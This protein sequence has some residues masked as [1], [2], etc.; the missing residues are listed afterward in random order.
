MTKFPVSGHHF[1]VLEH[2]FP[3]LE[4]PF[5]FQIIFFLFRTS[6][7]AVS[8]F[9][10]RPVPDFGCPGPSRPGFYLSRCPEKLHRPVPLETLDET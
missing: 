5:L 9:V 2:T 7:S 8:R 6:F 4:H 1:P 10:L 3:V